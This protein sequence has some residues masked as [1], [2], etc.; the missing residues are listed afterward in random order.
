MK[1]GEAGDVVVSVMWV[2]VLEEVRPDYA[3]FRAVCTRSG[4]RLDYS[5]TTYRGEDD[6]ANLWECQLNPAPAIS[7]EMALGV[8]NVPL[9]AIEAGKVDGLGQERLSA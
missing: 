2:W 7:W 5:P 6:V 8:G 3:R 1:P 9:A 4:D